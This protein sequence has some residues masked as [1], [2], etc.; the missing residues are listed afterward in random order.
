MGLVIP[1]SSTLAV[2]DGYAIILG[3][4]LRQRGI[5]LIVI[6]GDWV[7]SLLSLAAACA[8]AGVIDLL[9]ELEG[10]YCP[11]KFC[12]RYQLSAIMAFLSWFPTAALSLINLWLL[13]SL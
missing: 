4:P 2:V 5:L 9:P 1:W 11:H 8:T 13:R 10:S 7:L 12:S 6:I 3:C